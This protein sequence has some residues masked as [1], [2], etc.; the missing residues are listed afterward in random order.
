MLPSWLKSLHV[1]Q[2]HDFSM[3]PLDFRTILKE[4]HFFKQLFDSWLVSQYKQLQDFQS[5]N[6]LTD[7]RVFFLRLNDCL[8]YIITVFAWYL[9][10]SVLFLCNTKPLCLC[11]WHQN[12]IFETFKNLFSPLAFHVATDHM[13]MM[14]IYMTC[15]LKMA[16]QKTGL[17][18]NAILLR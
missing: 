6:F 15:P 3:L 17:Y 10:I 8:G 16:L 18:L 1:Y 5:E 2:S 14:W 11:E 9:Q 12:L 7:I 4:K 13:E